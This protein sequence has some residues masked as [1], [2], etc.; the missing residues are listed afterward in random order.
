MCEVMLMGVVG[1]KPTGV[2]TS[3][4]T[5]VV[6]GNTVVLAGMTTVVAAIVVIL[7][8][9]VTVTAGRTLVTAGIVTVFA[10]TVTVVA[11]EQAPNAMTTR[12]SERNDVS[13]NL[14]FM[15]PS[16]QLSSVTRKYLISYIIIPPMSITGGEN[17]SVG[18]EF[19]YFDN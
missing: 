5:K 8:G 9:R 3:G 12:I 13:N 17:I 14:V 16:L 19:N 4:G 18:N 11:L 6:S 15:F 2:S 10:G 1:K 7:P